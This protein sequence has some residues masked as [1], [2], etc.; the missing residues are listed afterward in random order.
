MLNKLFVI[1]LIIFV[2][3]FHRTS[4]QMDDIKSG[5]ILG[6]KG[7]INYSKF[8]GD[9]M[10]KATVC[11]ICTAAMNYVTLLSSGLFA[12]FKILNN[13]SIQ[14]EVLYSQKGAD[15]SVMSNAYTKEIIIFKMEYV[16]LPL[17]FKYNIWIHR[18]GYLSLFTGPVLNLNLSAKADY[19][20]K[21]SGKTDTTVSYNNLE[22]HIIRPKTY[23]AAFGAGYSFDT[24]LGIIGF[25]FRYTLPFNNFGKEPSGKPDIYSIG[26]YEELKAKTSVYTFMLSYGIKF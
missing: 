3:F 20:I 12:E 14:P 13:F 2:F 22:S 6:A 10:P 16:D 11:E 19:S 23:S 1:S 26:R 24:G 7:G 4:A 25:D 15:Y 9:D 5:I 8:I 17:L 18:G 21:Y